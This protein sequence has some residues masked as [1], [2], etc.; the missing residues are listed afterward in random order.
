MVQPGALA[1]LALCCALASA[2][3]S[4][5]S[6]EPDPV[7]QAQLLFQTGQ[8]KYDTHD[9]LGAIEAFTAAYA[10]AES[11]PDPQRRDLALARLRYNLARAHVYAY[12][13]DRQGEHLELARRLIADY[14][15]DERALGSDPDTDTDVQQLEQDLAQRERAQ[16]T[17]DHP[18]TNPARQQ[19]QRR[20]GIT[21]L[22]LAAP[23]AGLAVAAGLIGA[24]AN[25]AFTSVTTQ[26]ARSAAQQRGRVS[27]VLF[28]VGVGL[29]VVSAATGATLLGVSMRTRRT[30][31]A[32]HA[33][34]TGLVFAGEF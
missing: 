4:D 13:I 27:N 12:D 15:A 8:A 10:V 5:A 11:I 14:R 23:C 34:P 2:P 24:Q 28:G 25:D 20:V 18:T 29:A 17:A 30:E 9:F 16:V 19:N 1:S 31:L 33:T 3:A 21:M 7:A 22:A 32:L 6:G 26:D